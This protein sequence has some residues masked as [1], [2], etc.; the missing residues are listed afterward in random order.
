MNLE[1]VLQYLSQEGHGDP[2]VDLFREFLPHDI[3]RGIV[4]LSMNPVPIHPYLETRRGS[5]QIIGRDRDLDRLREKMESVSG[6]FAGGSGLV[7]GDMNFHFIIPEYEPLMFPRTE[8]GI[9][10]ASVSFAFS[11]IQQT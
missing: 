5:F 4:L 9:Q 1:P 10:E 3:E 7:L 2:G 11:F 8:S 6:A